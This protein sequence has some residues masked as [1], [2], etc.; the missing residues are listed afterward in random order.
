MD[1]FAGELTP[2]IWSISYLKKDIQKIIWKVFALNNIVSVACKLDIIRGRKQIWSSYEKL[3]VY[4]I[5]K[6]D[7]DIFFYQICIL[8]YIGE[9]S[10]TG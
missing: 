10:L 1:C 9:C 7:M 2:V 8:C 5:L 6:M 3:G 4:L